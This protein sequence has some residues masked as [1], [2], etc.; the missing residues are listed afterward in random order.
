MASRPVVEIQFGILLAGWVECILDQFEEEAHCDQEIE[1][2]S[3]TNGLQHYL[4]SFLHGYPVNKL[5][6]R[7][8][9]SEILD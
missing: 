1:H 3:K 8:F 9:S 7:A 6:R 2:C 5:E 4:V